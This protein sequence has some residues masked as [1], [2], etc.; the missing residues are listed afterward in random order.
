ME[1]PKGGGQKGMP[2][3]PNEGLLSSNLGGVPPHVL[4]VISVCCLMALNRSLSVSTV[5]GS[6]GVSWA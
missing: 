2:L 3:L 4:T 1:D 5:D 6:S